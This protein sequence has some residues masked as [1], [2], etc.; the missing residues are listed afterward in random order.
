M[1]K[2]IN[3]ANPEITIVAPNDLIREV[4]G[5]CWQLGGTQPRTFPKHLWRIEV[6]QE[7]QG[8]DEA[9]VE[10]SWNGACDNKLDPYSMGQAYCE[11]FK[12]GANWQMANAIRKEI[13][14]EE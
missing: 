10:K 12:A 9:A 1:T 4:G 7:P 13:L 2:L 11:G 5:N 6:E 8:L 3:I 14:R